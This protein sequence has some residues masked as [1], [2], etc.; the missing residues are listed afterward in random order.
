MFNEWGEKMRPK[1]AP[2]EGLSKGVEA[3]ICTQRQMQQAAKISLINNGQELTLIY[4][5]GFDPC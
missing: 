3:S 5:E 2:I 4:P 1:V